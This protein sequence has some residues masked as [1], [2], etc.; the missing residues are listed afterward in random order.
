MIDALH[1]KPKTHFC[2]AVKPSKSKKIVQVQQNQKSVILKN[3][4]KLKF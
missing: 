2:Q 4:A 3:S 1:N